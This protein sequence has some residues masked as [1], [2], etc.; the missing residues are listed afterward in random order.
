M[1]VRSTI[2]EDINPELVQWAR[3]NLKN[4]PDTENYHKMISGAAY[5]SMDPEL[6]TLRLESTD[7]TL[8]YAA[9]R[10]QDYKTMDDFA[11]VREAAIGKIFGSIGKKVWV[12]PPFNVDYGS[13]IKVGDNFYSNFNATILDCSIVDIGKNVKLGPNVTITTASH[14]LDVEQ[15]IN[16]KEMAYPVIIKDNVWIAANAVILPGVTIGKNSVVAAG[17]VVSR[18]VPDNVVVGGVPAKVIRHIK[19]G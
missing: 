9:I 16:G 2:Q 4:I 18:D 5:D 15:R 13:N 19:N 11:A 8:D 14:P 3:D 6:A 10:F 17:A 1:S 7:K 12:E